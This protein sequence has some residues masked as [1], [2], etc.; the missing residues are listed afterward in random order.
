MPGSLRLPRAQRGSHRWLCVALALAAAALQP[1]A[2]ARADS[3]FTLPYPHQFGVIPAATYDVQHTRVGGAQLSM[4]R[5]ENGLVRVFGSTGIDDG[6]R[7]RMTALLEPVQ[8]PRGLRLVSQESRSVDQNGAPL[9]VLRIDH[10]TREGSCSSPGKDGVLATEILRLPDSD[11]VVN[12]PLHLLFQPL[13]RGEV[14]STQFQLFLCRGGPRLLDVQA[15]LAPPNGSKAHL[16]EVVYAPDFGLLTM[17]VG[18]LLPRFSFWFDEREPHR[19]MA[20]H[21]PLYSKGPEVYV[22]RDGVE[23]S[24]LVHEER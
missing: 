4:E 5:L 21:L 6:A 15:K 23:A 11:R 24:W 3:A 8:K 2:S 9:G 16:R 10:R 20:H 1:A 19:W 13:V 17:L 7:T 18:G 12:V 22:V 14:E